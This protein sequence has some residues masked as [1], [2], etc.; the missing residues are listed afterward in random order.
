MGKNLGSILDL[1]GR[2]AVAGVGAESA[3]LEGQA[4]KRKDDQAN[5]LTQLKQQQDAAEF[6]Q[7]KRLT[8]AQIGNYESLAKGRAEG[9][10]PP[11]ETF[12]VA[13]QTVLDPATGKPT[14][15]RYGNR[16]GRR[17]EDD[18]PVP[19]A[20]RATRI[21]PLSTPGID[22]AVERARA[23]T[24]VE[25][26]MGG[27][28]SA[29]PTES[30]E[31]SYMYAQMMRESGPTID[32]LSPLV[33]KDAISA[34]LSPVVETGE[35]FTGPGSLSNRIPGMGDNEQQLLNAARMFAAGVLR[36]ESGAA[37]TPAELRDTFAR[38]IPLG[39][40]SDALVQQ[41]LANRRSVEAIMGDLSLPAS[42]YYK[43]IKQFYPNSTPPA[44]PTQGEPPPMPSGGSP[45]SPAQ[46]Q[47]PA[48]S[49][50]EWKASKG[51]TP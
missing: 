16:G 30:Q 36:K 12:G 20:Q 48:V 21:D 22:A 4:I 25:Q 28:T 34:A 43:R 51:R 46:G 40:D 1:L 27:S 9:T 24:R 17:V 33:N 45:P 49:F 41:K 14:L 18:L 19:D 10:I 31:K 8:D 13:P 23:L 15:V 39:G 11:A 2:G 7:R 26:E 3:K 37:I 35:R 47:S 38:F 50:E 32:R 42:E 6:E 29:R 5:L 44:Q